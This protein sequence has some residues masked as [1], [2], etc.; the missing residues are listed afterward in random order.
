MKASHLAK[1]L[2]DAVLSEVQRLK[3]LSIKDLSALGRAGRTAVAIINNHDYEIT[4]WSEPVAGSAS[5]LFVVLAGAWQRRLVGST[6]A[7]G[8]NKF[9]TLGSTILIIA[10]TGNQGSGTRE[11]CIILHCA[12]AR[13]G[14]NADGRAWPGVCGSNMREPV[15]M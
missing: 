13:A 2:D 7:L 1:I 11:V 3:S 5:G 10:D 4:A 9:M 8:Y 15:A 12:L 6:Q 14:L